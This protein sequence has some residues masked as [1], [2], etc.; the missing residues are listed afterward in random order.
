MSSRNDISDILH[1]P[2]IG[3]YPDKKK[4]ERKREKEEEEKRNKRTRRAFQIVSGVP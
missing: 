2:I 4:K 1:D 3:I